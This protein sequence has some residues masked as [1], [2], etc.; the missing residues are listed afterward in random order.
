MRSRSPAVAAVTE[1][2]SVTT[3]PTPEGGRPSG[4]D[5]ALQEFEHYRMMA[6]S[7]SD[8]VMRVSLGGVIEWVSPGITET[9]GWLPSDWVGKR[10]ID[11]VRPDHRDQFVAGVREVVTSGADSRFEFPVVCADGAS[12]WMES[13][14]RLANPDAGLSYR[15]IR[16]RDVTA[17]HDAAQRLAASESMFRQAMDN[18]PIGMCLVAPTGEF[19][20]VNTSLCELLGRDESTLQAT[21]WQQMTHPDDLSVDQGLVDEVVA[22]RRDSY[23]LRKRYLRP[24]GQVVWGDLAVSGVRDGNGALLFLISQIVDMTAAVNADQHLNEVLDLLKQSER[25]FRLLAENTSDIIVLAAQTGEVEWVSSSLTVHLGWQPEEWIGQRP[26]HFAHPED[27]ARLRQRRD[28]VAHGEAATSRLRFRDSQGS[29]HWV[30][31]RA[32]PYRDETGR[33]H[34]VMAAISVI[35]DLVTQE[36][37]LQ[38]QASHDDLT[39]LLNREEAYNRVTALMAD[40]SRHGTTTFLAFVDVDNLKTINDDY[41][42]PAGDE[43]LRIVAERITQSL[44]DEDVVARIGGDELLL[45][46]PGLAHTVDAL[47]LVNRALSA[48][49]MPHTDRHGNQLRPRVSIG[50]TELTPGEDIEVAVRRADNA[51][52]AAKANRGNHVRLS[53]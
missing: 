30:E 48:I 45:A 42:H 4:D 20:A 14:G 21:T 44:R 34:G 32:A 52:Y 36:R 8:I 5:D 49:N 28:R 6:E 26:D 43:L 2:A 39:G 35:D 10:N 27:V 13:I 17:Q 19:I 46:L 22:G 51:M 25:R 50:L 40:D 15:V 24:D 38:H 16:L 29:F 18:A 12:V 9:L 23:R 41:G 37:A 3:N 11:I 47:N 33:V 31:S 7:T 53:Q 1:H